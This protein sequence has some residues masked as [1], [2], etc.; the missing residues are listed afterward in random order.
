[1]IYFCLYFYNLISYVFDVF[2]LNCFNFKFLNIYY[3][4]FVRHLF[5]ILNL[6]Y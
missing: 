5:N 6:T 2:T 4:Y 3:F 1:M